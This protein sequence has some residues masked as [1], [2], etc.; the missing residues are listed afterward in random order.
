MEAR[1]EVPTLGPVRS[2]ESSRPSVFQTKGFVVA[3]TMAALAVLFL[4]L[5]NLSYLLGSVYQ[6]PSRY[7]ALE[8]L[9]VDY[10]GGIV[11]QSMLAAYQRLKAPGFP[12]FSVENTTQYPSSDAI[13]QAI[14][15][16]QYWG[17]IYSTAGASERLSAALQGGRAATVYDANDALSYVWN[18]IRYPASSASVL[19]GSFPQMVEATRVAYNAINGTA[20]LASLARKD[21]AAVQAFLNPIGASDINLQPA[22]QASAVF[23]NTISMAMPIIQQFFFILALNGIS[24]RFGLYT[25]LPAKTFGLVRLAVSL[26]YTLFGSLMMTGYIWA[27]RESWSVDGS[28]FVVTWMLLWL[29]MHIYYCILDCAAA[30]LPQ[31]VLPFLV[32]TVIFLSIT[33]TA[34]PFEIS[35]AFYRWGYALPAY[36]VYQLLTDVWSGGPAT[37]LYRA[38]PIL[39]SWWVLGLIL[40]TL[41]LVRMRRVMAKTASSGNESSAGE[42]KAVTGTTDDGGGNT[43]VRNDESPTGAS[44]HAPTVRDDGSPA[45]ASEH[46][47]TVGNDESPAGASEHVPKEE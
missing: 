32:V 27:F 24:L 46:A 17:A 20:A 1:P 45:R 23:Y 3:T 4:F 22:A 34:N 29:L 6:Q 30:V 37:Q 33:S 28:Q 26:I 21:E 40:A 7:H 10:D 25:T 16:R 13:F 15:H 31:P 44:E 11:G 42:E 12:T 47:P 41:G 19:A 35:P 36:E 9:M 5:A 39:F 18:G 2:D 38:L 14:R 8:V 43:A